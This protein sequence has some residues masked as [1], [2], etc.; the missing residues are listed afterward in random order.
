MKSGRSIGEWVDA[1]NRPQIAVSSV[2]GKEYV[3]IEWRYF[4]TE[5]GRSFDFLEAQMHS[6]SVCA[7]APA[8]KMGIGVTGPVS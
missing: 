2:G 6:Y 3:L 8:Y 4:C 1:L 7:A 5:C